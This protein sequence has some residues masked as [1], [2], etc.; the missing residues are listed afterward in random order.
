MQN[1]S[2]SENSTY[3]AHFRFR[4]EMQLK[5]IYESNFIL[6]SITEDLQL[7]C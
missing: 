1:N 4:C 3:V 5:G 7:W 2:Q 6:R